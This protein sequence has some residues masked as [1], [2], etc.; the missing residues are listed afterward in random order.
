MPKVKVPRKSVSIDMTAMTDVA[1]LLLTFFI[2][3]A[4][5]R[6][7]EPVMIDTPSSRAE[8]PG[9]EDRMT[10]A[11]DK[12]GKAYISFSIPKRR[13]KVLEN[14]TAQYSSKYPQLTT[15]T[16]KQKQ[17]F[18]AVEMFGYPIN[19]LPGLLNLSIDDINKIKDMPGVPLDSADNQL[20]DWINAARYSA[21]DEEKDLAFAIKGD[22]TSNIV[23]VQKIMDTMKKRDIYRFNLLTTLEGK[24][25]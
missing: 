14:L 21:A 23:T 20:G 2:L 12:D 6:P 16:E 22:K 7:S 9:P 11:V 5:F 19:Q 10:I 4:K 25:D 8:I 24:V 1:F 13:A 3:T 18:V 15:L 17:K